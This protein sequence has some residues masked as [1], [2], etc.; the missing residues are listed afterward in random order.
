MAG[1]LF[2]TVFKCFR[3]VPRVRVRQYAGMHVSRWTD[4]HRSARST[5]TKNARKKARNTYAHASQVLTCVAVRRMTR[6]SR[7]SI[8]DV[9]GQDPDLSFFHGIW[10]VPETKNKLQ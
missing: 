3:G 7:S 9:L 1:T 8:M 4:G 10:Q 2:A 6:P 5:Y